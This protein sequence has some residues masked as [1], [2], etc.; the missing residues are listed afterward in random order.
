M[1]EYKVGDR[2]RS[3]ISSVQLIVVRSDA[4]ASE[5]ACDGVALVGPGVEFVPATAASGDGPKIEMGKRYEDQGA[6]VELLCVAP[7]LGQ[8]TVDGSPLQ[9]KAPKPLPASD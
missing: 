6:R 7:G 8:L 9:I 5:I 2:L 1:S 3:T 4:S